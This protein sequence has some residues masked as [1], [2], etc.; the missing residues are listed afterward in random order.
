MMVTELGREVDAMIPWSYEAIH[1]FFDVNNMFMARRMFGAGLQDGEGNLSLNNARLVEEDDKNI[2]TFVSS[3]EASIAR[4]RRAANP[5]NA[6]IAVN[7]KFFHLKSAAAKSAPVDESLAFRLAVAAV[8]G[9]VYRD[10]VLL[11]GDRFVLALAQANPASSIV[12]RSGFSVPPL[13]RNIAVRASLF[14]DD[15]DVLYVVER[16][17]AIVES[18]ICFTQPLAISYLHGM[19]DIVVYNPLSSAG[20]DQYLEFHLGVNVLHPPHTAALAFLVTSIT[21]HDKFV[22]YRVDFSRSYY[23]GLAADE[24]RIEFNSFEPGSKYLAGGTVAYADDWLRDI[25]L[26]I[27]G[28]ESVKPTPG[29]LYK[30]VRNLAGGGH[31][32][33]GARGRGRTRSV[34]TAATAPRAAAG[35]AGCRPR[36]RRPG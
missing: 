26:G 11:V 9:D 8:M 2:A 14:H 10:D 24:K 21:V 6:I 19:D 7:K 28:S 3:Y 1:D 30:R 15:E 35:L 17:S 31:G 36:R 12:V 29:V 22:E 16:R 27:Y 23:D 18:C 32:R 25:L 33:G 20:S 13:S 5:V 4:A 34:S